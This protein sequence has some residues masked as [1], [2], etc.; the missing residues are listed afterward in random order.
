MC[1]LSNGVRVIA[2][3]CCIFSKL[4]KTKHTS[5]CAYVHVSLSKGGTITSIQQSFH[6]CEAK[7]RDVCLATGGL[8]IQ[9]SLCR[10]AWKHCLPVFFVFFSL[11]LRSDMYLIVFMYR[12]FKK[13]IC[14]ENTGFACS[15]EMLPWL[16]LQSIQM[17]NESWGAK[18]VHSEMGFTSSWSTLVINGENCSLAVQLITVTLP[19]WHTI[20]M[21]IVNRHIIQNVHVY[22]NKNVNIHFIYLFI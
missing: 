21:N 4:I 7:I 18:M 22:F 13:D 1:G 20:K 2:S 5:M 6:S 8:L 9:E 3:V 10:W 12:A 14:I 16:L 17:F 11:S 19:D 15:V